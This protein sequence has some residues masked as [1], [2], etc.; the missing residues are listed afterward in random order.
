MLGKQVTLFRLLG[1]A[2]RVHVS[3]LV[4]AALVTWTL[5]TQVFGVTGRFSP[6]LN[7]TL[8]VAGTVGLFVSVVIHEL[9]HSL[10]ARHFG[11]DMKGITL[12][13]FGGVAELDEEPPSAKAEFLMAIAGPAASVALA[14][15]FYGLVG[16]LTSLG[17]VLSLQALLGWLGLINLILA[18]FNLIPGFPLDGGRVLRAGLWAWRGNIR[19]ATRI[20][21]EVGSIF[22]FILIA[23]GILDVLMGAAIAG[24][25]LFLIGLFI[26]YAAK[27]GY[28]QVLVKQLL[29][30]EP[31]SRLMNAEPVTVQADLP[32]ANFVE[33]YVY[34]H[35]FPMFPVLRDGHLAGLAGPRQLRQIS[36]DQW[37]GKTVGDICQPCSADNTV[38]V[39]EDAM[40]AL[41][42]MNRTD[43][44][45]LLVVQKGHLVG[46]MT[47]KDLMK[48]MTLKMELEGESVDSLHLPQAK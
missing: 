36:Q 21:S 41:S 45:Y 30:K 42:I 46:I 37:P 20:A 6:T 17:P 1:F 40:A 28:Q 26:R 43:V 35:H 38:G 2:V 22:G 18:I 11:M 7:W 33:D 34:K 14:G 25:W 47:L 39:D 44:T 23:L 31:I 32:I 27:Q 8:G 10:V 12:F 16:I 19:W 3:W 5:A 24:L 15:I 29:S 4:I 48:F 9:C 13:I